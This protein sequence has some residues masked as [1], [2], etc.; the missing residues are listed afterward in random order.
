[1]GMEQR[2]AWTYTLDDLEIKEQMLLQ[3]VIGCKLANDHYLATIVVN[4]GRDQ[5]GG[6]ICKGIEKMHR[7]PDR[8]QC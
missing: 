2:K 1:M 3:S 8:Q 7:S 5:I 4:L 6:R